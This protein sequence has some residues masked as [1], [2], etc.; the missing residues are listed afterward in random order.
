MYTCR[1]LARH[2]L[3]LGLVGSYQENVTEWDTRSSLPIRHHYYV[4]MS[5]H[6]HKSVPILYMLPRSKTPT[7]NQPI[8]LNWLVPGSSMYNLFQCL[9]SYRPPPPRFHHHVIPVQLP[10][11]HTTGS[12]PTPSLV[13]AHAQ[14][15]ACEAPHG[16]Q[17][18]R[19][20]RQRT[21]IV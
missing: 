2:L 5:V 19:L 10:K 6:C 20:S 12:W 16:G 15:S 1:F 7:R 3:L 4:T 18:A 13:S 17:L 11:Q 9:H 21:V 14:L 8:N